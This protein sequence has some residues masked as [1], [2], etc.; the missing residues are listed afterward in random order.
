MNR[1]VN[2]S[3]VVM[4]LILMLARIA[5]RLVP[6]LGD[7]SE[8][9]T[10]IPYRCGESVLRVSKCEVNLRPVQVVRQLPTAP[11]ANMVYL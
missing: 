9:V 10:P 6:Q 1:G 4:S 7:K 5:C 2:L 3:G 11:A 8:V